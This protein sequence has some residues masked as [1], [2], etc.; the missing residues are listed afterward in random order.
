MG[1]I[2]VRR[3]S[4]AARKEQPPKN[5]NIAQSWIVDQIDPY[6]NASNFLRPLLVDYT[7][8]WTCRL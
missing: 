1:V 4:D 6:L 8:L 2:V 3:K 7:P 5:L